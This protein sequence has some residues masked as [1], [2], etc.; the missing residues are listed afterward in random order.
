M[1]QKRKMPD[2]QHALRGMFETD[3]EQYTCWC[4]F[5]E[6]DVLWISSPQ[7]PDE[8]AYIGLKCDGETVEVIAVGTMVE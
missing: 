7:T 6:D 2:L 8:G 4:R 1:N 5:D 3:D